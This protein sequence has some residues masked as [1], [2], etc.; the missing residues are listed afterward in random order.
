MRKRLALILLRWAFKNANVATEDM[1]IQ[2]QVP[3][4]SRRS[5]SSVPAAPTSV[6]LISRP[7]TAS[8][9]GDIML[10]GGIGPAPNGAS[11]LTKR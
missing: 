2:F 10:E 6:K 7:S 9:Q 8:N 11:P 5:S 1:D 4:R 3:P